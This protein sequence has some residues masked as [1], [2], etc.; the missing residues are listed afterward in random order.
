MKSPYSQY[1]IGYLQ[2]GF[3][4]QRFTP[5][6]VTRHALK[7]A[8]LHPE[9]FTQV[10]G[11]DALIQAR[12][13]TH[14]WG[15]GTQ[16]SELDGIPFAVKDLFD[17]TGYA[18]TRGSKLFSAVSDSTSPLVVAL[19][20]SGAV[21]IGKTNLSEFAYSGL[22]LNP[23][24]GTPTQTYNDNAYIT[25]GSSCGSAA[26]VLESIVPFT[27]G[28]DTAGSIRIPSSY[29]GLVGFRASRKRYDS[30]GL[31]PLSPSLDTTGPIAHCVDDIQ[32]VD[33][34][35]YPSKESQASVGNAGVVFDAQFCQQL[36]LDSDTRRAF[37][38]SLD[39]LQN[40]GIAVEDV[41]LNTL[42]A[43]LDLI[44]NI[45]WLG[46]IEAY[47]TYE[48]LINTDKLGQV[49]PLV[50]QRLAAS[51]RLSA[52]HVSY[53]YQQREKLQKQL[54]DELAGRAFLMP[55]TLTTA[56]LL[57]QVTQS[58]ESFNE[59]NMNAL[60]LTMIGS[61]LDCPGISLPNGYSSNGLPTSLLLS[62]CS[63]N[64]DA[65]IGLAKTLEP[66]IAS[67]LSQ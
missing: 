18:T 28:T 42:D 4:E 9:I 32:L 38:Q 37:D 31:A 1:S 50:A 8:R 13:A 48:D 23:H 63:G 26:A 7:H 27:L 59:H 65:L 10:C 3:R 44:K 40:A 6:D 25:G 53:L 2:Q 12:E 19:M 24:F 60:R 17:L 43:T 34:V 35:L 11:E 30:R 47:L 61:Y 57:S 36:P 66:V 45:G 39:A 54:S 62:Q 51:N 15:N 33:R 16:I 49:D 55:T 41:R 29:C 20:E 5:M 52:T 22:G 14:R 46:S 21:L 58:V 64:D 67:L 56:P